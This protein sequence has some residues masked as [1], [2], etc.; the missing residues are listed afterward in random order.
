MYALKTT[1][2][3]CSIRHLL[4]SI[5]LRS[6]HFT[7]DKQYSRR[8]N[9]K[10]PG[11]GNLGNGTV[12]LRRLDTGPSEQP[13]SLVIQTAHENYLFNCGE[14]FERS[15]HSAGVSSGRIAHAFLTQRSWSC[16][17]GIVGLQVNKV[18]S[19]GALPTFHGPENLWEIVKHTVRL[20]SAG[21]FS[22]NNF[23]PDIVTTSDCYEDK[24][25]RFDTIPIKNAYHTDREVYAYLCV[26]KPTDA[27]ISAKRIFELDIPYTA[28]V[29]LNSGE[30]VTLDDGRL[31]QPADLSDAR[32]QKRFL[33]KILHV[34]LFCAVVGVLKIF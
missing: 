3:C 9:N 7:K 6:R 4:R 28:I 15:L 11:N 14:N 17:G 27:Q 16:L 21:A 5:A 25:F 12:C 19:T 2:Y 1:N 13:A 22:K 30:D 29:R 8:K 34:R 18:A 33:S 10:R 24:N 23:S 26:M 32:D 20:S 31:I